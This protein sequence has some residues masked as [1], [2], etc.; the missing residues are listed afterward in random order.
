MF[1]D[2]FAVVEVNRTCRLLLLLWLCE[3]EKKSLRQQGL[4]P[5]IARRVVNSQANLGWR[6]A[7]EASRGILYDD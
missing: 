1:Q 5:E 3:G 2:N 7:I 4:G 6:V